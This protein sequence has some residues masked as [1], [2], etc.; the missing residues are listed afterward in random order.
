[1]LNE[2]TREPLQRAEN[3]AVDHHRRM[4]FAVRPDIERAE[5]SGHIQI[6]LH[7]AALPFAADGVAQSVFELWAVE[8]AFAGVEGVFVPGR[9]QRLR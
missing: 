2:N 7:S 3:R 8:R 9:L 4:L 5:P 1:M 6:H